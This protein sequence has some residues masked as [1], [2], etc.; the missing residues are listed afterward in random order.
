MEKF[1]KI[2]PEKELHKMIDFTYFAF[3]SSANFCARKPPSHPEKV[4]KAY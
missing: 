3:T 4:Y 2:S 1:I